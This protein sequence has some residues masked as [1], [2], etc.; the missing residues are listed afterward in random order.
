MTETNWAALQ[1]RLLLRYDA[2]K[3]VL[4][5]RLGSAQL[6]GDALQETWLR[7]ERGG[8][9]DRVHSIDSYLLRIAFNLARDQLRSESRRLTISEVEI[10]L[11]VPDDAP[12]PAQTAVAR[13]DLRTLKA[14][15]AE[16]PPRQRAI[17]LAARLDGVP[18]REIAR[19]YGI[20]QRLVQRELQEAQD[21][22]AARFRTWKGKRFTSEPPETS[23]RQDPGAAVPRKPLSP[24]TEE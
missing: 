1:R 5:R 21:Y 18:R 11:R 19:R 24:E 9:L 6:A 14:I 23:S 10:L 4:T 2:L 17:L 13:S 15:M 3:M 20:S 8:E 22:C 16:L 12:D 7:L